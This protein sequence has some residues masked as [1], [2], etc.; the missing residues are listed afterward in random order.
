MLTEKHFRMMK[1]TRGFINTGRGP[2][3]DEAATDQARC[4]K[5]WIAGA[6]LDV[7]EIE[8]PRQNNPLL[9]WTTSSSA[10]TTPRP[11]RASIRRRK[12]RVG[13]ELAL[14]LSR[15]LAD[16]LRQSVGARTNGAAPLAADIDG[17]RAEQLGQPE[18]GRC[19]PPAT[20]SGPSHEM[21]GAGGFE[22]PHGGIKIRCL[23]T[24]RRPNRARVRRRHDVNGR[25]PSTTSPA[26]PDP[27]AASAAPAD[28]EQAEAGRAGAAHARQQAARRRASAPAAAPI[29]GCSAIAGGCRSLRRRARSPA[30]A[31]ASGQASGSAAGAPNSP[32]AR[33]EHLGGRH[34]H[35]RIDQQRCP[36]AGSAGAADRRSPMPPIRAGRPSEADRH[37]GAKAERQSGQIALPGAIPTAGTAAAAPPRRRPSRRR[38]PTRPAGA[39]RASARASADV[40]PASA[41]ARAARSTR[42]SGPVASTAPNGPRQLAATVVAPARPSARRPR[43]EHR[44]AVEQMVAVGAPAERRAGTD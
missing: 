35:A 11:R 39:C 14:V 38:C 27:A 42:L 4:R 37:V 5:G 21:A 1:K 43:R 3:V 18:T 13:Q 26:Q 22:P 33:A 32:C 40:P 15:P 44:Q 2:T 41:S 20:N 24:W 36:H 25:R 17:T 30:I 31:A 16:E 29:G 28:G 12:R 34:R 23:T 6:G 19:R 8:P 7:L 9:R 10:R